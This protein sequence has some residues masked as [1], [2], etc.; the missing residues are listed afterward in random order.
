MDQFIAKWNGKGIDWDQ[1]FGFQCV[2]LYRQYV[3]EVLGFPQSPAVRGAVNVWDTYLPEYF[4]RIPNTPTGV[5]Q[6]GDIVI[7]GTGAGSYGHI[8]VCVSANTSS[9]TSFD[10]NWP[11]GSLCHLQNHNYS[12]VLGWLHPKGNQMGVIEELQKACEIKDQTIIARDATI[13][14]L[15]SACSVK[16][17]S[18]MGLTDKLSA[19]ESKPPQVIEKPVIIEKEVVHELTL[20]EAISFVWTVIWNKIKNL[21]KE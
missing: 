20:G 17:S 8:A 7:W 3:K 2:D 19:C 1:Q 12:N 11:V 21:K 4:D 6:K 16:D 15:Q 13:R 14:D 10:Q 18:I 9:F 5:P